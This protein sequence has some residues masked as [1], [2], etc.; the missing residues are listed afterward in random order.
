MHYEKNTRV[1][2]R[3]TQ[4]IIFQVCHPATPL[5]TLSHAR[6]GETVLNALTLR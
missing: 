4:E 5:Y 2:L 1:T 6:G 3:T